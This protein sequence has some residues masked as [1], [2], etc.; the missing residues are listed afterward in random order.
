MEIEQFH[1]QAAIICFLINHILKTWSKLY[2]NQLYFIARILLLIIG[3]HNL[4]TTL[5]QLRGLLL[6]ATYT[7][8]DDSG[9]L[10]L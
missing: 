8:L 9:I 4:L 10:E 6:R 3:K 7:S 1:S 2:L 5:T